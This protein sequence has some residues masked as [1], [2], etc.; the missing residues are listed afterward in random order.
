M[1]PVAA[2]LFIKLV[3]LSKFPVILLHYGEYRFFSALNFHTT[4]QELHFKPKW[5]ALS[6]L[7][8][9]H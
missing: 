2:T 5:H 3:K 1:C 4:Q 9:A 8:F 6:Y 7:I